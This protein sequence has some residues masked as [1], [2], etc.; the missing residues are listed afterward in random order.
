[1]SSRHRSILI[2]SQ[3]EVATV[4]QIPH[5]ANNTTSDE[6]IINTLAEQQG[7]NIEKKSEK[8]LE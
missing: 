8:I 2:G 3:K 4:N 7:D 6:T 5:M 1:M